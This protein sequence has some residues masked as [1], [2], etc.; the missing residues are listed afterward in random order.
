MYAVGAR[1]GEIPGAAMQK[2]APKRVLAIDYGRKRIGLALSD[3]L[4]LTAQPLA[5]LMRTNRQ[6]DIHRLRQICREHAV[7][8]IVVGSPVHMSGET[9]AM[10]GEAA[11]F[12]KRLQKELSIP[13]QLEDERLTSWEADQISVE[14][15]RSSRRRRAPKDHIAAAVLLREYL[16]RKRGA[17][18]AA[19]GK[20]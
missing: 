10:A 11:R 6:N 3:E 15:K 18:S 1:I 2:S 12:A 16:E 7:G 9:S 14:V 5:I 8:L 4:C 13:V 19:G 20:D 17:A